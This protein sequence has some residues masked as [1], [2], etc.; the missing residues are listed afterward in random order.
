MS[1]EPGK[2]SELTQVQRNALMSALGCKSIHR[3]NNGD[4]LPAGFEPDEIIIDSGV[5]ASTDPFTFTAIPD[6]YI[7][8]IIGKDP[9]GYDDNLAIAGSISNSEI[10]ILAFQEIPLVVSSQ[11]SLGSP[12]CIDEGFTVTPFIGLRL[13]IFLVKI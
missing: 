12:R 4:S 8:N 9:V 6:Y 5:F 7:E 3:M 1:I 13:I 10:G 2:I 11:A